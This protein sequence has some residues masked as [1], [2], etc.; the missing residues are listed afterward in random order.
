MKL[1]TNN[2][3]FNDI[4][5]VGS[6]ASTA[7]KAMAS[8]GVVTGDNRGNFNPTAAATRAE[9]ATIF[10]RLDEYLNG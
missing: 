8:I 9:V 4:S 5:S 6:Y 10:M 1:P 3:S 2:A 7:V